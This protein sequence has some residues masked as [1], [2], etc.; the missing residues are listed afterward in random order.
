MSQIKE[1]NIGDNINTHDDSDI[2]HGLK[3]VVQIYRKNKETGEV[4]FWNESHNII[5]ISGYQV[6]LMKLFG[7]FLDSSH[8]KITDNLTRDTTLA[9]PDLNNVLN[10]GVD[11]SG[12]RPG[13]NDGYTVMDEDISSN[14]I[15]QG[16]MVGN[17]GSGEDTVT[18]K[19]TAYNFI[20]LRNPIPFQQTLSSNPTVAGKYLGCYF[21]NS[22]DGEIP[23]SAYIKKFDTTPHIYHSWWTDNQR[24]D[25]VDPVTQN[26]LGPNA[27]NGAPKTNRIESYVE[28]QLSLSDTDCIEYFS[29]AGNNQTA[30]INEIGLVAFDTIPGTRSIVEK[31]Y[32]KKI[33]D[34]LMII[35]TKKGDVVPTDSQNKICKVLANEIHAILDPIINAQTFTQNNLKKFLSD[36]PTYTDTDIESGSS[37]DYDMLQELFATADS[38]NVEAYYN[39]N[40][41]I[42]YITDTFMNN[43]EAV[44]TT[45]LT[46]DEAQRIKLITYYT[47]PS[48]PIS[49]NWEILINYR[50]YAN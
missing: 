20:S 41:T 21:G 11:P 5:P 30:M 14:Y 32:E 4:S 28:C 19:N 36:L 29:H 40:D 26:D 35:F 17:G 23:Q 48:I 38:I 39:K 50:I 37:V 22:P 44:G 34:Y 49:T 13:S 46:I 33:Q 9:I 1:V 18:T 7:L 2:T 16:F 25:Y 15:C 10:I 24:W 27:I 45:S 31:C 8:G 12:E 47:F 42:Q 6:I 3:G 43:L